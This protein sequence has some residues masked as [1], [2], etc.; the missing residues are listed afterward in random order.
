VSGATKLELSSAKQRH[1]K[2]TFKRC[3]L[4]VQKCRLQLFPVVLTHL[5]ELYSSAINQIPTLS[6]EKVM[7]RCET[8]GNLRLTF[9][10]LESGKENK[11]F[12]VDFSHR[13]QLFLCLSSQLAKD[14]QITTIKAPINLCNRHALSNYIV[15][16]AQTLLNA[17][18]FIYEPFQKFAN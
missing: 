6:E 1:T 11:K 9:Y 10:C 12:A 15:H 2:Q 13:T 17:R 18:Y 7:S 8:R 5:N 4:V 16:S 14:Y 3:N